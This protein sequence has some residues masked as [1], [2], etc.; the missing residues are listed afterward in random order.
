MRAECQ[1]YIGL[2]KLQLDKKELAISSLLR[3]VTLD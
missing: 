2:S 3:A 1:H